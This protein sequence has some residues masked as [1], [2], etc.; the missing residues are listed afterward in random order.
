MDSIVV[1]QVQLFKQ[2]NISILVV[3]SLF[4]IN[5][6]LGISNSM[7]PG[8]V[9]SNIYIIRNCEIIRFFFRVSDV[10]AT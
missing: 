2:V 4:I 8:K 9:L 5:R 1:H 3:C 6:I 7:N 10:A